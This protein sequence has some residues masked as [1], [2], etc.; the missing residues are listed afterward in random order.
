M[1]VEIQVSV[2]ELFDKISILKIKINS[3]IRES[4]ER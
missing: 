2:G 4:K 3:Q 1:K